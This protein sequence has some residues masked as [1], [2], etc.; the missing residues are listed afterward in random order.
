MSTTQ[1]STPT[2]TPRTRPSRGEAGPPLLGLAAISTGLF[3]TGVVVTSVMAGAVWPSPFEDSDTVLAFFRDHG[4]AVR[5]G[6]FFQFGSAVPLA[7]YAATVSTRLRNLGIRNPGA[8]IALVGGV[9]SAVFVGLSALISWTMV[10]P[11][12]V[13]DPAVLTALT[14]LSF[15]AAGP[16]AVVPFGLL[17]AG[18]AVPGLLG[19]LLPR[20]FA[21]AGLALALVAELC[22]LTLLLDGAAYLLPVA[23]F[24]GLAWL[25]AAGVMLPKHRA[26][27]TA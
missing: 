25:I 13:S 3:V 11:D 15:L 19:G 26:P 14:N 5:L 1:Q 8:T 20:G 4:D 22:A 24:G 16:G 23:R 18:I 21:I 27:V 17:L 2:T 6:T 12:V 9:L 10:R 7:I